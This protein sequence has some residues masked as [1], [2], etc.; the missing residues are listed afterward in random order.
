MIDMQRTGVLSI[1][2]V[3]DAVARRDYQ[4]VGQMVIDIRNNNKLNDSQ[5]AQREEKLRQDLLK[6]EAIYF[7]TMPELAA[8]MIGMYMADPKGF[9][10]RAPAAAAITRQLLNQINSPNAGLVKF[11]SMP[12]ATVVAIIMANLLAGE[13]EEQEEQGMLNLGRGALTA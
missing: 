7:Q 12:L 4:T 1:S 8:D 9:K 5:K 11:Y 10:K 13:R 3:G 2:G 6:Y